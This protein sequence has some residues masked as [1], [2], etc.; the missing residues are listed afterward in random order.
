MIKPTKSA[1]PISLTG[2]ASEC[3]NTKYVSGIVLAQT[4]AMANS[5]GS[6]R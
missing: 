6:A 1:M 2:N 3:A 5:T 4:R